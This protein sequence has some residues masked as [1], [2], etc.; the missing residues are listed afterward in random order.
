MLTLMCPEEVDSCCDLV[1][2]ELS[3]FW[4]SKGEGMLVGGVEATT[5]KIRRPVS[6]TPQLRKVISFLSFSPDL[7]FSLSICYRVMLFDV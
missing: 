3:F 1:C 6:R 2:R 7:P 5:D 4:D